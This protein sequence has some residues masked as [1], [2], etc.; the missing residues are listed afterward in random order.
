MNVF[1]HSVIEAFVSG[2]LFKMVEKVF[3]IAAR[4]EGSR[5]ALNSA[6]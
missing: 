5:E 2:T 1:K 3:M 4:K 6:G